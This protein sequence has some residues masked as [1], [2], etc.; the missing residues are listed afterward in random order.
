[1]RRI[2]GLLVLLILAYP[3]TLF[4][5]DLGSVHESA[6]MIPIA[7]DVD[8]VVVGERPPASPRRWKQRGM[9]R[10]FFS[11]LPDPTWGRTF[12]PRIVYGWNRGKSPSMK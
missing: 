2:T 7:Y 11:P 1:M 4:G 5:E 8:V 10:A 3:L 6:R 9:E 12:A